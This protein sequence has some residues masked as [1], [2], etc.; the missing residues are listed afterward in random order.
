MTAVELCLA[1][2]RLPAAIYNLQ[3]APPTYQ[4]RSVRG[5]GIEAAPEA[6]ENDG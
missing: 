6:D 4:I 1:Q 3:G 2:Q 5:H